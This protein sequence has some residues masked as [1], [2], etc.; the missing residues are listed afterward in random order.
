VKD[1]TVFETISLPA[2]DTAALDELLHRDLPDL[3]ATAAAHVQTHLAVLGAG[4]E[5]WVGDGMPRIA[6]VSAGNDHEVCPFCA[7]DLHGSPLITHYRAYFSA[8]Y[9]GLKTAIADAIRSINATHGGDVPAAFERTVRVAVQSRDF[10][11]SFADVPVIDIDTAAAARAWKAARQA[12]L[13]A[14]QAKTSGA[15]RS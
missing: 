8:G 12:V 6:A 3:E 11:K 10:W 14:L 13:A 4:G 2:F 15:T 1:Q 7:Q 5:K 9:S